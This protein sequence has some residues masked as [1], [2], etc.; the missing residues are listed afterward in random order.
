MGLTYQQLQPVADQLNA[1]EDAV[2]AVRS[3]L[4]P[5]YPDNSLSY[6][7]IA[8]LKA[9]AAE[10]RRVARALFRAVLELEQSAPTATD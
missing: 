5:L 6:G 4:V 7:D 8:T 10:L 9:S 2:S 3:G 1:A